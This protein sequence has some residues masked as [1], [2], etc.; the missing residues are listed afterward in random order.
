MHQYNVQIGIRE[1]FYQDLRAILASDPIF[2]SFPFLVEPALA[3][4]L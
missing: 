4:R 2:V 1:Y 3:A